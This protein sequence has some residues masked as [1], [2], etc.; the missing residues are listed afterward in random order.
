DYLNFLYAG[1]MNTL[2]QDESQRAFQDYVADAQRRLDHDL[3]FPN[4]PKQL[5]PGEDVRS[6]DGR[7]QVS[8]QVAVMAVNERLLQT[9]ME[10]NPELSF[11]ME[12]SFAF[13]S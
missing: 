3:K 12:E 10:K 6:E 1:Q 4:E 13:K 7:T 2:T 9:L 11:A 5:L 8:G